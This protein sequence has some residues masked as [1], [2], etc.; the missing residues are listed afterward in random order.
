MSP[1]GTYFPLYVESLNDLVPCFF[2]LDRQN[3][4]IW[5]PVHIRDMESLPASIHKEF[6]E[7]GKWVVLNSRHR[8][9]SIQIDQTHEQ[10]NDLVKRSGSAVG[11]TENPSAVNK[12]MITGPKQARLLKVFDQEYISEDGDKRQHHEEVMSTQLKS[13]SGAHHQWDEQSLHHR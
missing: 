12:W 6:E 2:A 9:S 7:P 8:F 5:T 11:L 3:C 1:Q 13:G 10:N 4:D